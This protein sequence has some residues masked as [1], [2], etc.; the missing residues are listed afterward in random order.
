VKA[1]GIE[2]DD[3]NRR[4]FQERGRC[5]ETQ[6]DDVITTRCHPTRSTVQPRLPGAEPRWRLE[7]QTCAGRFLCVVVTPRPGGILR[8]ITCWPLSGKHRSGYLA[9][10]RSIIR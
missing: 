5:T 1:R 2:W 8:P 7:G 6:V 4:H 3:N 9:W 10:R